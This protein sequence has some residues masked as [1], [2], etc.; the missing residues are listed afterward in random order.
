MATR[1]RRTR[2]KP[3][4]KAAPEPAEQDVEEVEEAEEEAT[5]PKAK[6]PDKKKVDRAKQDADATKEL[7][8]RTG[9]HP[10]VKNREEGDNESIADVAAELNMTSGKAAYLLMKDA[11]A[12][13]KVPA[14]E[15]EDDDEL[16]QAI[17]DARNEADEYSSWGWLSARAG[18]TEGWIKNE[19][20]DAGAYEPKAQNISTV[21]A[22]KRKPAE[23]DE[24]P[25]VEEE[26]EEKPAPAKRRRRARGNA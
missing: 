8:R 17:I 4:T 18:V 11:V 12:K 25:E 2:T 19:L 7:L 13:G 14:I 5:K 22:A 21:R 1:T 6:S 9:E 10:R 3:A 15:A 20:Q 23:E 16:V 24:E 26:P